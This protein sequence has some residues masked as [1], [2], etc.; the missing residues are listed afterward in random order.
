M[1]DLGK[2]KR[3][4]SH[5]YAVTTAFFLFFIGVYLHFYYQ[6]AA[7]QVAESNQNYFDA[8]AATTIAAR[9]NQFN[10]AL[11]GYLK[12]EQTYDPRFGNGKLY[13]NIGNT[14]YQLEEYPLAVLYYYRAKHLRPFDSHVKTNLNV[15][16]SKL[17]LPP[18]KENSA[19]AHIF[20]FHVLLPLPVRLQLFFMIA[21][22]AVI[23][24]S[25]NV[26]KPTKKIK[27]AAIILGAMTTF[28]FLS[29]MYTYFLENPEAVVVKSTSMYRGAG[30]QFAP[31]NENLLKAGSKVVLLQ[32]DQE[33]QWLKVEDENDV[34]GFVPHS[35]LRVIF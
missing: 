28:L 7:N 17:E 18:A 16:L 13:Y 3:F 27:N 5:P 9:K 26:W 32:S 8:E 14:Y 29:L 22:S 15:A 31:V 35:N 2:I 34:V 23:T 21:L 24:I 4:L 33:G 19:I 20:F 1:I 10:S 6:S 12:M 11:E 30:K 25:I